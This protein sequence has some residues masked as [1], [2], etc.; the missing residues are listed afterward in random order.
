LGAQRAI[1]ILGIFVRL[2][3]RDGKPQYLQHLPRLW[4]NVERNLAA[5]HL[6]ALKNWFDRC[7]PEDRRGTLG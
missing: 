1:K 3:R 7:Y 2:W 5:P 6:A 4:R